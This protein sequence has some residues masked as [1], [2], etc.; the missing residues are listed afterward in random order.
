[1]ATVE[2]K[3]AALGRDGLPKLGRDGR[4]VRALAFSSGGYNTAFHLGAI[5]ALMVSR[6]RAP[7]VVVG[8]SAGAITATALAEV[9]Q[10]PTEGERVARF[11]EVLEC[12]RAAP[13]ALFRALAP[14]PYQISSQKPLLPQPLPIHAESERKDR[15]AAMRAR[16]GLI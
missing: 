16:A 7:D 9:L 2:N 5:H 8:L 12:Y 11:R 15:A 6:G 4:P 10:K 13:G 3:A 1:M 14:D